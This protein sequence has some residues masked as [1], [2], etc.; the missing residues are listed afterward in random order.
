MFVLTFA[1]IGWRGKSTLFGVMVRSHLGN[2]S[3]E[4]RRLMIT[5]S[6]PSIHAI[7]WDDT[8]QSS[9]IRGQTGECSKARRVKLH[10]GILSVRLVSVLIPP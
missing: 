9:V 7:G 8:P 10:V 5:V 6:R 4:R 3:L 1:K 2:V